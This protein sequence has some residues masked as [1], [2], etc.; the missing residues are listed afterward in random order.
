MNHGIN[1][2]PGGKR[3]REKGKKWEKN[4]EEGGKERGGSKVLWQ[5]K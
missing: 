5:I 3:K 4:G 1:I 2:H